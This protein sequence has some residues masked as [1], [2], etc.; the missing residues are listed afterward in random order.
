[1]AAAGVAATLT[2]SIA[3]G[4]PPTSKQELQNPVDKYPKS[5]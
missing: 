5:P 3:Q 2:P 4:N 1:M